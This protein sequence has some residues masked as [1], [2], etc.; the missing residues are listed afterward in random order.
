MDKVRILRDLE[1]IAGGI[2]AIKS[3]CKPEQENTKQLFDEWQEL[4]F[5]I[6]DMVE[7]DDNA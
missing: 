4:I 7:D 1:Y 6:I 2:T 5:C 3:M